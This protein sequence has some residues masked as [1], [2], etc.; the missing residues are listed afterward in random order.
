MK[1][2]ALPL[3]LLCA[4][5][6]PQTGSPRGHPQPEFVGKVWVSTD[7]SAA[8]GTFRIFLPDGTLV[9]DSCWETY[10]LA[11]WRTIDGR[12][13]EWTEDTA[14]IVAQITQLT[15]ERLHLRLQLGGGSQGGDLSPGASA[16]RLSRHA[17]VSQDV[18]TCGVRPPVAPAPELK[19]DGA[20][21]P[22]KV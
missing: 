1:R 5:T 15:G 14:R 11:P 4:C 3:V 10:R 6:T 8:P 7:A 20:G 13:I 2:Y 19:Q 16:Y 12:R 21:R 18:S 17:A 9:M 22:P